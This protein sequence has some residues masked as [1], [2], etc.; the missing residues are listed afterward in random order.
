MRG[1]AQLQWDFLPRFTLCVP[2]TVPKICFGAL[3]GKL[4]IDLGG[5]QGNFP[6]HKDNFL[7]LQ[8]I[9]YVAYNPL[10]LTL[11][12]HMQDC[13]VQICTFI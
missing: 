11:N 1:L 6:L 9:D 3:G 4:K 8:N 13:V 12:R 5:T 10:R 7:H 2:F